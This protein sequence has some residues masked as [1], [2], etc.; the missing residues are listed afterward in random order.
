MLEELRWVR[1]DLNHTRVVLTGETSRGLEMI[2][3]QITSVTSLRSFSN[4][5]LKPW[6]CYEGTVYAF[7][8]DSL[9]SRNRFKQIATL[10]SGMTFN[11]T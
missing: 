7:S 4:A 10:E 2:R 3:K 9:I 11:L 1:L 6:Q 5:D 8:N